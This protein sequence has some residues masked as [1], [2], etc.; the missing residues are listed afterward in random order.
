MMTTY[1]SAGVEDATYYRYY[2]DSNYDTYDSP[3]GF[4][5][6]SAEIG[7]LKFV[8]NTASLQR[9][10]AAGIDYLTAPDM[11]TPGSW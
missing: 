6:S 5:D 11:I 2:T 1:D 3:S 8:F 7:R 4:A 9:M 10:T